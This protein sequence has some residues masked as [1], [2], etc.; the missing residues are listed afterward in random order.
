[1]HEDRWTLEI[2][3]PFSS[4]RYPETGD[5][6]W[7]AILYRN[8]P[9]DRRYQMF[10]AK[11][12]RDVSCFV[13]SYTPLT[14]IEKLPSAGGLVAAPF[15]TASETSL[16][17]DGLGSPLES[18]GTDFEGGLDAKWTPNANTAIDATVN[19]DF[20][21]IESDVADIPTNERI[22]VFLP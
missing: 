4:L 20:S 3:I 11:L 12:P 1:V 9:R 7:T 10:T 17:E 5:Q 19:P 21:Q 18:Q 8:Y 6:K 2:R 14:G 15:V 16:P 13:C 22:A